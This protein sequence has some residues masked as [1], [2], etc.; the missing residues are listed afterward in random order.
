M[1]KLTISQSLDREYK[2]KPIDEKKFSDFKSALRKLFR[3]ISDGQREET[4][5]EH[6]KMFL[7]ETF[8]KDYYAASEGDIDLVVKVNGDRKS[9]SALLI[10]AKSTINRSE[11]I[12]SGNLNGKAMQE[13]L[14]YYLHERVLNKN[15]NLKYMIVNNVYEFFIFNAHEFEAKFF[16]NK[17]LLRKF[18]DF[19][20]GRLSGKDTG[21]FYKEIASEYINKVQDSLECTHFNLKDYEKYLKDENKGSGKLADLYRIFSDTHLMKKTVK[22]DSNSL[23]KEFY[24][25]LLYIIGLEEKK[26]DNKPVIVRMQEEERQSASLLENT[27]SQLA[28]VSYKKRSKMKKYGDTE[29][30]QNFNVALELCIT[31]VNRVLFLKLL[32]S[33]LQNY[34]KGD[35]R[36]KFL[37]SSKIKD[38]DDLNDLFFK[39]LARDYHLR[40]TEDL[41]GFECVPYLNSSLF[42]ET[43][44]EDEVISISSLSQKRDMPLYKKSVL[45]K[46]KQK[47]QST[48]M[49]TLGYLFS[50]LDAYSFSN[51]GEEIQTE[52]KT[53]INAS[54]LGLIFE[55]ING[56]KDGAVFTPGYITMYMCREAVLRAVI[57]KFNEH[58]G[59]SCKTIEDVKNK[60]YDRKEAD[61]L[62]NSIRIC[63]PSVGSGH[64]LVSALNEMIRIKFELGVLFDREGGRLKKSDY[65][66]LIENDELIITEEDGR[67]FSYIPGNEERQRIQEM[68]FHEKRTIIEN[69]LFGVDLNPNSAKICHLRLWIELLKNTYYTKESGYKHLE[70]LPNIDVNIKCGNSLVHRFDLGD[71][72]KSVLKNTGISVKEYREAVRRYKN[73]K[74]KNDKSELDE[75]IRNIKNT[76]H[77]EM[78]KADKRIRLRQEKEIELNLMNNR[79]FELNK[80]ERGRISLLEKEI[81]ALN[82]QIEDIKSN[83]MYLNAF[84]WRIEFPELLDDDGNFIGFDCVIGNPPY[85]Q[86]QKMGMDSDT[87]GKIG[88]M[89][90]NK[91]GDISALFY[92]MGVNLLKGNGSLLYITTN[93][94]MRTEYGQN[95]RNFLATKTYPDTLIDFLEYQV[96][97][98]V[99]V[100]VNM[101]F[102]KKT[103][104][105]GD[106]LVCAVDKQ[107]FCIEEMGDYFSRNLSVFTFSPNESWAI[108]SPFAREI[109]RKVEAN[110]VPLNEWNIEINYGIK[111]GNNDVFILDNKGKRD[112]ILNNCT[113]KDERIRTAEIIRPILRGQDI[114]KYEN[115]YNDKWI[116]ATFPSRGYCID[117]YP[118]LKDYLLSFG[119]ER[120]EQS[121]NTHIINGKEIKSRKKTNNKS[122]ETQDSISYWDNFSRPKIIWGEISDNPK[123]FLDEIG[124]YYC[125]ATTFFMTGEDLWY[126]LACINSSII[127]QYFSFLGTTTGE[128][129]VR[130]KKYKVLEIPIPPIKDLSLKSRIVSLAKELQSN[131]NNSKPQENELEKLIRYLYGLE[132]G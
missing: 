65:N 46:R 121:G 44:L 45:L 91:K 120:L 21:F 76:L 90:Y 73:A 96:F 82:S 64:F 1:K 117:D 36:Y 109:K 38:Y 3:N 113:T 71:N 18:V 37:S 15:L 47:N 19:K 102:L 130:W 78:G 100:R 11:M 32:E 118:A 106:S 122:F 88:Y 112:E 72:I 42:E 116:I 123:F 67:I 62:I 40:Q 59:W 84:E 101:L 87:L 61:L 30:E 28:G 70:T 115:K 26:V 132:E 81:K 99:T 55:K 105:N 27:I 79:L 39:I 4:Q 22:N 58:F 16:R 54:V 5:K 104:Y 10:E 103:P 129:T 83:K 29:E 80:K 41:V 17:V 25:E 50:F 69:C 14:Y 94:W 33:Q 74:S 93:T 111:T 114:S 92:E 2:K 85:I 6:L 56:H 126:I 7:V 34:H 57:Q 43:E 68:L 53:L 119:I 86:L 13:L 49:G 63:D 110:G 125:E 75:T 20:E 23:N 128:G 66:L 95:L 98:S 124:I 12:T 52:S 9:D 8:Y 51:E 108:L 107:N 97:D 60:D 127:K 89:T 35:E 77:T 31:W 24:N 131:A 48:E